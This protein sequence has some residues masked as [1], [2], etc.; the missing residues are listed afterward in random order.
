[1]KNEITTNSF[2]LNTLRNDLTRHYET[3]SL[4]SSLIIHHLDDLH[5]SNE[6][7]F[8]DPLVRK[9][10]FELTLSVH[11]L[12]IKATKKVILNDIR[13]VLENHL[14][15]YDIFERYLYNQIPEITSDQVFFYSV[16]HS[17]SFSI[18]DE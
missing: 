4:F 6:K 2:W 14:D 13:M 9:S 12:N 15:N 10:L 8:N 11:S 7:A 17:E 16:I 18:P 1:M 5:E 3:L